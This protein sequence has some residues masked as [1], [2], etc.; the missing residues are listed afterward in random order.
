MLKNLL[1]FLQTKNVIWVFDQK[2]K[3]SENQL[4][5]LSICGNS[6]I[7]NFEVPAHIEH[8]DRLG[9]EER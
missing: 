5:D 4:L 3:K 9:Y 8:N 1:E 7:S 2:C 6:L